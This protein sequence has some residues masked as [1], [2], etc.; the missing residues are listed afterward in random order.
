VF[1]P[2]EDLD[3][4]PPAIIDSHLNDANGWVQISEHSSGGGMEA[5]GGGNQINQ[6]RRVGEFNPREIAAGALL[7][8][9]GVTRLIES[10]IT[11]GT[12]G[13]T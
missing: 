11:N 7:A 2:K 9:S 8:V 1:P 12:G 10:W 6:R 13:V 4:L 5:K 3:I